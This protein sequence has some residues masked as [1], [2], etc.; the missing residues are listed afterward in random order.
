MRDKHNYL[1]LLFFISYFISAFINSNFYKCLI[2]AIY[3]STDIIKA[4]L[5]I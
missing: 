2:E 3:K 1:L 4:D 5:V